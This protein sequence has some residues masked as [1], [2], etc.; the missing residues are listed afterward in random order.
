[1]GTVA[2]GVGSGEM[3]LT[4]ASGCEAHQYVLRA[5]FGADMSTPAVELNG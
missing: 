5:S 2:A 4:S 3:P 1:M